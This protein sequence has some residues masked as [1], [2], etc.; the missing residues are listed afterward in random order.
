MEH[1]HPRRPAREEHP[2][3][4]GAVPGGLF[5]SPSRRRSANFLTLFPRAGL[6]CVRFG[7]IRRQFAAYFK[8]LT[9]EQIDELTASFKLENCKQRE[10][11]N[12]ILR[13]RA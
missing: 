1:L 9:F 8:D 4:G 3:L 10:G 12:E 7:L 11:L 13:S 5:L 2:R 6:T